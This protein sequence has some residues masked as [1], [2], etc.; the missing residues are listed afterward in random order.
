[1]TIKYSGTK[2]AKLLKKTQTFVAQLRAFSTVINTF[3]QV[4]PDIAGIVW[5][6]LGLILE[7]CPLY[8]KAPG[9]HNWWASQ[10]L[11]YLPA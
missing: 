4:K 6:P 5:G 1:M 3:V 10:W 11:L 7:V 8:D 9:I 2:T